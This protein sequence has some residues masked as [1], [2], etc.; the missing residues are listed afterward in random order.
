MIDRIRKIPVQ[1]RL[2]LYWW[3]FNLGLCASVLAFAAR[4]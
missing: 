1:R 2:G 4:G 3:I